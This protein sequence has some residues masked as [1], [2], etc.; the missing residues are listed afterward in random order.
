MS[1]PNRRITMLSPRDPLDALVSAGACRDGW[2]QHGGVAVPNLPG[3]RI[4]EPHGRGSIHLGED[5]HA[6]HPFRHGGRAG[7]R[8][9]HAAAVHAAQG[10]PRLRGEERSGLFLGPCRCNIAVCRDRLLRGTI[11]NRTCGVHKNLYIWPFL[12]TIFGPINYGPP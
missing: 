1:A 11:V 7:A 12:L 5:A 9:H 2:R 3:F 4:T 6:H 8:G 10:H